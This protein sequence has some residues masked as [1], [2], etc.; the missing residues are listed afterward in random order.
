MLPRN[1]M[2]TFSVTYHQ[3]SYYWR[4][5]LLC[6]WMI[7]LDL[8]SVI[9]VFLRLTGLISHMSRH[10]PVYSHHASLLTG[11]LLTY[12]S[13]PA[14]QILPTLDCLPLSGL[15][16]SWTKTSRWRGP[17]VEH[18]SLAGVLSLSCARHVADG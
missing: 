6:L 8:V 7:Q 9:L 11:S 4:R 5:S 3:S 10:F 2:V 14:A 18:R 17:A 15:Q 16:S 1:T 13:L 12:H